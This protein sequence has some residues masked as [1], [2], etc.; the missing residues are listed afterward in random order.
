MYDIKWLEHHVVA[1]GVYLMVF[2]AFQIANTWNVL[3][4]T[5]NQ[6]TFADHLSSKHITDKNHSL[7]KQISHSMLYFSSILSSLAQHSA[8]SINAKYRKQGP[9]LQ[10]NIHII[11]YKCIKLMT[12]WL[13]RFSV[14]FGSNLHLRLEENHIWHQDCMAYFQRYIPIDARSGASTSFPP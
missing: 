5:L 7:L 10:T 1:I 4:G 12:L 6:N 8:V 11:K 3:S 9:D 2:C 13:Y 14:F